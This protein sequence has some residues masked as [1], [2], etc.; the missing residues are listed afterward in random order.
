MSTP[1]GMVHSVRQ[2]TAH[3]ERACTGLVGPGTMTLS[4]GGLIRYPLDVGIDR[5]QIL[6]GTGTGNRDRD[7]ESNPG[8]DRDRDRDRQSWPGFK[9]GFWIPALIESHCIKLTIF[10]LF[11]RQKIAKHWT[12]QE[13][14]A[15]PYWM[16]L[17]RIK[18]G[19]II[20]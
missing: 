16:R 17:E 9:P 8:R 13:L 6:A 14:D 10:Y 4:G 18:Y 1:A 19:K 2:K 12:T 5:D 11:I 20:A 7:F 15:W 3:G